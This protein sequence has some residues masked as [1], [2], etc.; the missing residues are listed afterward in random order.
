MGLPLQMLHCISQLNI[1]NWIQRKDD[2]P[3]PLMTWR[4]RNQAV[5]RNMITERSGRTKQ[6]CGE[7]MEQGITQPHERPG[8]PLLLALGYLRICPDNEPPTTESSRNRV[9]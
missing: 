9:L 1:F 5:L 7:R 2:K 3:E 8:L 6:V 4:N